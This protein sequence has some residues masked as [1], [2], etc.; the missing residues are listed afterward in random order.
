MTFP[1]IALTVSVATL[2]YVLWNGW[3]LRKLQRR[4]EQ[5]RRQIGG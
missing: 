1:L 4:I 2:A 5:H 3:Q